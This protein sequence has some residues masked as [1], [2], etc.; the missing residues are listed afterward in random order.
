MLLTGDCAVIRDL[1]S[2]LGTLGPKGSCA[3]FTEAQFLASSILCCASYEFPR[4]LCLAVCVE[5]LGLNTEI[6]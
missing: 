1:L 4:V 3:D 5:V 2:V 6:M